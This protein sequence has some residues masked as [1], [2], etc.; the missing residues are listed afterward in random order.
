ME[1]VS[2]VLDAVIEV[3]TYGRSKVQ[4]ERTEEVMH[5]VSENVPAGEVEGGGGLDAVT[6]ETH[7]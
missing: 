1:V 4:W 2:D 6:V 3:M 5:A 7:C